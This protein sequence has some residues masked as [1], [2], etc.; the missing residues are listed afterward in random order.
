[1]AT[2]KKGNRDCT[3][4]KPANPATNGRTSGWPLLFPAY[5]AWRWGR[6][7]IGRLLRVIKDRLLGLENGQREPLIHELAKGF[8][9]GDA[10]GHFRHRLRAHEPA[11]TLA[12]ENI[13]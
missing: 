2:S 13:G 12:M 11:V 7:A 6:R 10:G 1:M 8:V 9:I 5:R 4:R 3:M